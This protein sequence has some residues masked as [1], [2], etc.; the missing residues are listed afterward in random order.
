MSIEQARGVSL[1][2]ARG[3]E[4]AREFP[5]IADDYRKGYTV[6]ELARA[7]PNYISQSV[8]QGSIWVELTRLIESKELA[9]LGRTRCKA[10]AKYRGSL[11]ATYPE[12]DFAMYLRWY[13]EGRFPLDK[14]ITRRYKLDDIN[15]ACDHLTAGEILGRAIIEY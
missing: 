5:E 13:R 7:C 14:L 9:S 11:G 2:E 1:S 8:A 15:Q 12:K 10:G 6:L 3:K 4:L